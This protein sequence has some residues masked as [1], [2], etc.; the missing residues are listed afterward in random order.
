MIK[1]FIFDFDGLI[2]DTETPIYR[3]WADVY[4]EHGY[5]LRLI[6]WEK[7]LG[8][9]DDNFDVY[10]HLIDLIKTPLDE[11]AIR[12]RVRRQYMNDIYQSDTRPGIR[13]LIQKATESG[14]RLAIGSSADRRWL[15]KHLNRLGLMEHFEAVISADDVTQVKPAPDIYLKVLEKLQLTGDECVV[16]EDSPNGLR[17]SHLAGIKCVIIPN[18]VSHALDTSDADLKLTKADELPLSE[19]LAKLQEQ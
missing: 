12:D 16:F 2:L 9:T 11:I 3:A 17:A 4:E 10:G 5:K 8:S 14:I 19:L 13:G 6:D 7:S 1:A 15:D 18:N